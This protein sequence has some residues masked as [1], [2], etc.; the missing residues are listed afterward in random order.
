MPRKNEIV[1]FCHEECK[2]KN[3]R[4]CAVASPRKGQ[5]RCPYHKYAQQTLTQFMKKNVNQS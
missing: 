1:P 4:W 3:W 2:G 5:G